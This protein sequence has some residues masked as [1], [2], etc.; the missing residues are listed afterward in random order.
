VDEKSGGVDFRKS[1]A[2]AGELIM[3]RFL[4]GAIPGYRLRFPASRLYGFTAQT[5]VGDARSS[6]VTAA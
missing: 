3:W 5:S 1:P 2:A 4:S 6:H